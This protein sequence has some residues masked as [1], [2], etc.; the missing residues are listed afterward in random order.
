MA[1]PAPPATSYAAMGTRVGL[2]DGDVLTTA[3]INAIAALLLAQDGNG[4]VQTINYVSIGP[5]AGLCTD[6]NDALWLT[7]NAYPFTNAGV[8]SWYPFVE[9]VDSVALYLGNLNT[10]GAATAFSFYYSPAMGGDGAITW[11]LKEQIGPQGLVS[12]LAE[13]TARQAGDAANAALVAA[14]SSRAIGAENS[15][16]ATL[17]TEA[18]QIAAIQSTLASAI[19]SIT[20][21]KFPA[22]GAASCATTAALAAYTASGSGSS[23][24]L[25]ANSNGAFPT[26]DGVAAALNNRVLVKNETSGNQP[27]NQLYTLTTLGTVSTPWVLT[28]A[29]DA[30][31]AALVNGLSV[32]VGG[33]TVNGNQTF[34][35]IDS[36][37][38]LGTS[39]TLWKHSAGGLGVRTSMFQGTA[40]PFT[41]ADIAAAAIGGTAICDTAET[42]SS[43]SNYTATASWRFE[44][45][46]ALTLSGAG[47]V[48]FAQPPAYD[49]FADPYLNVFIYSST[50]RVKF[51]YP[52]E[53]SPYWW[54]GKYNGS[55]VQADTIAMTRAF[56]YAVW[57][58]DGAGPY[59]MC[60]IPPGFFVCAAGTSQA[61]AGS[62]NTSGT[63]IRVYSRYMKFRAKVPGTVRWY[64]DPT[65]VITGANQ[66]FF[67]SGSPNFDGTGSFY[68]ASKNPAFIGA[69][70]GGPICT[71]CH[72]VGAIDPAKV[73]YGFLW[74][75][76]DYVMDPTPYSGAFLGANRLCVPIYRQGSYGALVSNSSF[77]GS[78]NDGCYIFGSATYFRVKA[79]HNGYFGGAAN[80]D[81]TRNGFTLAGWQDLLTPGLTSNKITLIDCETIAN[82]NTGMCVGANA[83]HVNITGST[84]NGS[85]DLAIEHIQS[86]G[87]IITQWAPVYTVVASQLMYVPGSTSNCPA[88][89]GGLVFQCTS[90]AGGITASS[91][92]GAMSSATVGQTGITDGTVTWQCVGTMPANG[93]VA[94]TVTRSFNLMDG[95]IP[96]SVFYPYGIGTV[97]TPTA[98]VGNG[99][100][101]A[102]SWVYN[103]A[104]EIVLKTIG[105]TVRNYGYSGNTSAPGGQVTAHNG[106]QIFVDQ[107]CD[108]CYTA[109]NN[110]VSI[111][112]GTLAFG[113]E[114]N[115]QARVWADVR[116]RNPQGTATS[117]AL[118]GVSGN[119]NSFDLKVDHDASPLYRSVFVEHAVSAPS[120]LEM[121]RIEVT[122]MG[123]ARDA[124]FLNVATAGSSVKKAIDIIGARAHNCNTSGA[125]STGFLNVSG[126]VSMTW[127]A[128]IRVRLCEASYAG[129]TNY[130]INISTNITGGLKFE[131]EDNKLNS[132]SW[133]L[134]YSHSGTP[135]LFNSTAAILS[136]TARN[137][138]LPGD[139]ETQGT[140]LPSAYTWR[141]GDRQW[142]RNAAAGAAFMDYCLQGND[143]TLSGTLSGTVNVT[144]TNGTDNGTYA[145]VGGAVAP[146]PGDVVVFASGPTG[147]YP[148]TRADSGVIYF[149]KNVNAGAS[150]IALSYASPAFKSPLLP[151]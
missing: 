2:V 97:A 22:D 147:S 109:N 31:S 113:T 107:E 106:G 93:R 18:A 43:G 14:E 28:I 118:L 76:I 57:A 141:A 25:T 24:A 79:V 128:L 133:K 46:G 132:G 38:T 88:G 85:A 10:V 58:M 9:S 119:L 75:G 17:A 94:S 131:V 47:N 12:M 77:Y 1:N 100:N 125:G 130:P 70:T 74:D 150:G 34:T 63:A 145:L 62:A 40:V 89:L 4:N 42:Y 71:G 137:N 149:E 84:D 91:L 151:S 96:A 33:G 27:Y 35:Q 138:G 129:V 123:C 104:N 11:L 13:I 65:S 142:R 44:S 8:T 80:G 110:M 108:S 32:F 135:A 98:I 68:G 116:Y 69:T 90:G 37:V 56:Q 59:S 51:S 20:Q 144:I 41:A 30:N 82:A 102:N 5:Y 26:I 101:A 55:T 146:S 134:N 64:I 23:L 105:E 115:N 126:S 136:V 81:S 53:I 87:D 117:S 112:V 148:V 122:G 3:D 45:A 124:I 72:F 52:G 95:A 50:G 114:A 48:T 92:P 61:A 60:S 111:S 7:R 143:G 99:I 140:A 49:K 39:N 54:G 19:S 15:I 127:P 6:A 67:T 120:V 83:Q 66:A 86:G 21:T 29:S 103:S 73:E 139:K 36:V 16:G 78:P 121:G